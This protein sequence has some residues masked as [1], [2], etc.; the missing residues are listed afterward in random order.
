VGEYAGHILQHDPA[1]AA[2]DGRDDLEERAAALASYLKPKKRAP[3]FVAA[4]NGSAVAS[5]RRHYP[6]CQGR[7][8]PPITITGMAAGELARAASGDRCRIPARL[9]RD[10]R[11]Q[12]SDINAAAYGISVEDMREALAAPQ[13][14]TD[15]LAGTL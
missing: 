7:T 1:I 12:L 9:G 2:G 11:N 3:L 15:E 10:D 14:W 6:V 8:H 5:G 13:I 4:R